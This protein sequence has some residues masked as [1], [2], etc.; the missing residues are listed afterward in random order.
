[1]RSFEFRIAI[2]RPVAAVFAVYTQPDTW[3]FCSYIRDTRWVVG[4]AWEVES[5]LRIETENTVGGTI[6]QVL[7][8]FEPNRRADFLSHFAGITLQTRATFYALSERETEVRV[9]GE[10]VGVFSRIAAFAIEN[11]IEQGSREF[12]EDLKHACEGTPV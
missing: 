11:V 10:F 8:H 4:Q 9:Q 5:R 1:M 6:D 12:F 7:M 3:R 2:R